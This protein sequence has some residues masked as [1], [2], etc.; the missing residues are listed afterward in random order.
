MKEYQVFAAL[1]G[2][3]SAPF[4]WLTNPGIPSRSIAKLKNQSN[5]KSI[6]CEVLIVD[7]NFRVNYNEAEHTNNIAQA[8]EAAVMNGWYRGQL[9][10]EKNKKAQLEVTLPRWQPLSLLQIRAGLSH[11]DNAVRVACTL[12]VVSV[13]LGAIGLLLGLLAI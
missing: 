13:A 3:I 1:K 10:V 12:A 5:K 7:E 4:V 9:G 8:E 6:Y 11:P 2:E